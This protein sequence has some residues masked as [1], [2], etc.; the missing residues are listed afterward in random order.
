MLQGISGGGEVELGQ[1]VVL[2]VVFSGSGEG[3]SYEW[4]KGDAIL[5]GV[6]AASHVIAA[7]GAMD[8][9]SYTVTV[10]N[11]GGSSTASTSL[12]VK[13]AAAPYILE[14]P[15]SLVRYVGQ[16]ASF[17]CRATGSYP[18]S[19]EWRK[20]GAPIPGA[21][22]ETLQF[23]ALTATDAGTYSVV[24]TN[25]LGSATS[26][27]ASLTVNAAVPL[28]LSSSAPYPATVTAGGS[29]TFSVY[30]TNGSY[31]YT[32][33]WRKEGLPIDGATQ[34]SFSIA[35]TRLEDAGNYSVVVTNPAGSVTSRE[36]ALVVNP[37]TP[38]SFVR[39]P[40]GVAI[41]EGQDA[42]LSVEVAGSPPFSFQWFKDGVPISDATLSSLRLT[43]LRQIDAGSYTVRVTNPA[44]PCDSNSAAIAVSPAIRP[45]ITR[46]PEAATVNYKASVNLS[47]TVTG[48]TPLR[49]QWR[50]NGADI[51]GANQSYFGIYT[52]L[53]ADSG[54]YTVVVTN[55]GG[56]ITSATAKIVVNPAV[57][58][59]IQTQPVSQ[60]V[61]AGAQVDFSVAATSAGAGDRTMVWRKNG[62]P[63]SGAIYSSYGI[64]A[65]T[66][67]DA[68]YYSVA[69]TGEAGTVISAPA[70]L[71]VLPPAPPSITHWPAS[72]IYASPGDSAR[73]DVWGIKSAGPLTYQWSK[74]GQP[75]AGGVYSA[76]EFGH[77]APTDY[78]VYTVTI[79]NAAAVVTSPPIVLGQE[80]HAIQRTTP[81]VDA[82]A[83]GDIVYFL[84]A[85]PSRIDRY[86]LKQERWLPSV[87]LTQAVAPTAF[88][89]APD[90]IYIAYGRILTRRP[91]DLGSETVI[92]NA[93]TDI[94]HLFTVGDWVYYY[95][96]GLAGYG[97]VR[98]SSLEIGSVVALNDLGNVVWAAKSGKLF[99]SGYIYASGQPECYAV[100]EDGAITEV[101]KPSSGGTLPVGLRVYVSPD[102]QWVASSS[103]VVSRTADMSY[104]RCLGDSFS[105]LG[106][107]ADGTPVCLRGRTLTMVDRSTF[108]ETARAD[109]GVYG[110]RLFIRGDIAYVFDTT[111]SG[112]S[113][114]PKKIS[115]TAFA[116]LQAR[117]TTNLPT[118]RYSVDD[119]FVGSEG[120][121]NVFSRSLQS[122]VRWS[123]VT[124][125][126]LPTI[127]LPAAPL[128]AFSQPGQSRVLLGY[129]NGRLAALSLQA[130][131][132]GEV[133][134]GNSPA[135]IAQVLDLNDMPVVRTGG[136]HL[137]LATDGSI[138]H[139][140]WQTIY[141][142]YLAWHPATGRLFAGSRSDGT[143]YVTVAPSG[144]ISTNYPNAGGYGTAY[145]P[146]RI[147]AEN[148]LAVTGNGR[149]VDLSVRP[150][151]ALAND[152]NDAVWL[153]GALY[154]MRELGGRTEIQRWARTSYLQTRRTAVSGRPV[155]LLRLSDA[156]LVAITTAQGTPIFTV[157]H[158]DLSVAGS[159]TG[160]MSI[161]T[162][163]QSQVAA[164]GSP[165]A[166]S[167]T[168]F[169]N[170]GDVAYQWIRNGAVLPGTTGPL[171]VL[172]A[173]QPS[174]VGLYAAAATD[175][176]SSASTTVA[177][178]G[179]AITTKVAGAGVEIGTNIVHANG[180]V[181]D[182][183]RL[184]GVAASISADAGQVARMSYVDLDNDIVQVE[185]S[186]AGTLSL[187][188]TGSSGPAEPLN[189]IQPGIRYMK[190]HAGIVIAGANETTHVSVFSVGRANA[191]N[192][193]LFRDDVSYDGLADLAYIAILSNDGKFGG[194]RCANANFF[195]TRGW[196]G[197]YAPGVHFNGPVYVGDINAFDDA[198]AVLMLGSAG[199][200]T[201][202]NGGDLAQSNNRPVQVSGLT[203]LKFAA[204]TTSHG[205]LF[206]AQQNKARLEQAGVDVTAAIVVNP[207]P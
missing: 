61:S 35:T 179:L 47:V 190:G 142:D 134:I 185:L 105:D 104:L 76:L 155:R 199:G 99:A 121:V 58:P 89:P 131:T 136:G 125:S 118:G 31:P 166:L 67:S 18:R 207:G 12:S 148:N 59:E 102:E 116:A 122:F 8:A 98:R 109:A 108:F 147:D 153:P 103:G 97:K 11:P 43:A 177:I 72:R 91:L 77:V 75:V 25:S 152:V 94:A 21:T 137:M 53:P 162:Q 93:P 195:A 149:I 87:S 10:T 9:G 84:T 160:R 49:F 82:V 192:Q 114:T 106:F 196:T 14:S 150:I 143:T 50:K 127:P 95:T 45:S 200:E 41:V 204:G 46:P 113:S 180:R 205:M 81:W 71:T 110:L 63:I 174:E 90:G 203:R 27:D 7:A 56:S 60:Q 92:T 173:V 6:N 159:S 69:I 100:A 2:T 130:S 184:D 187:V 30:I 111:S 178:V 88:V 145:P 161:L 79:S 51:P 181:F 128:T 23:A 17:G 132:V 38:V 96:I 78:G 120:V 188:L 124:Q 42:Y 154:T 112:S 156:R 171:L 34:S 73:L 168:E 202:I 62:V 163:P 44:G 138:R 194:L 39:Q 183:I 37:P 141:G 36:A 29:V 83:A 74:D 117:G 123:A 48:S 198:S 144:A 86:D 158:E 191:V 24:I 175:F 201:L 172:E 126:F 40:Q 4:R 26:A 70:L 32:Y 133:Q 20:N 189:Y 164:P 16:P 139:V 13:P 176:K 165:V 57:L 64:N 68:G 80:E 146:L 186:G 66:A 129:P 65:V 169:G 170:A 135:P 151:G 193:G 167:A 197:V 157:L 19:F 33:Q 206:P 55:A 5:A 1:R 182:Q 115:R 52:A 22:G 101:K 3:Q 140:A 85:A 54:D 15:R 28:V 107:F 119:A